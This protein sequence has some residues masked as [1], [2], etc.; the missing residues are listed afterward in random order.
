MKRPSSNSKSVKNDIKLN[1]F[2]KLDIELIKTRRSTAQGR[3]K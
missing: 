2:S 3:T 1:T